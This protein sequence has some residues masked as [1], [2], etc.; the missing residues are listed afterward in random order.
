MHMKQS[1]VIL[2]SIMISV[3]LSCIFAYLSNS[4]TVGI[5]AI[6]VFFVLSCGALLLI[7]KRDKG[8]K[9]DDF[10]NNL[11][12]MGKDESDKYLR[13]LYPDLIQSEARF[14]SQ[15]RLISNCVKYSA[16]GEE[17]VASNYRYAKKV[18]AK[19]III[20]THNADKRAL[21]LAYR[22]D[23]PTKIINF[24]NF[25]KMLKKDNL[26]PPTNNVLLKRRSLKSVITGLAYIPIKYFA[27]S[28]ISTAIMSL[29]VPLKLYYLIFSAINAL[30]GIG[31]F[32][33]QQKQT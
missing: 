7:K 16:L 5:I 13:K 28:C 33:I 29:F 23:I 25:Y 27:F 3:L 11:L 1:D 21:N 24:K 26:L 22:L 4:W 30:I 18:N 20:F 8:L 17:D 15:D 14:L 2:L 12:L 19:E 9:K 31:A 32:A 6:I 10:L